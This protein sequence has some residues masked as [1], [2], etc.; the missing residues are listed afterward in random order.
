MSNQSFQI[1]NP[2][3][4]WGR[5]QSPD[6]QH[7]MLFPLNFLTPFTS[8]PLPGDAEYAVPFPP[9]LEQ[10]YDQGNTPCCGGVTGCQNQTAMNS[11]PGE[12][13]KYHWHDLYDLSR[14]IENIPPQIEGT[15]VRGIGQA[16]K[17]GLREVVN[18]VMQ[19]RDPANGINDFYWTT[20][21]D[22]VRSAIAVGKQPVCFGINWYQAMNNIEMVNGEAWIVKSI[23][24]TDDWGDV[25]GGHMILGY[26]VFDSKQA[27]RLLGSWIAQGFPPVLI[28]YP[29]LQRLLDDAGECMVVFDRKNEPAPPPV[30]SAKRV[31]IYSGLNARNG[32][33]DTTAS[34]LFT[35]K[36]TALLAIEDVQTD[37]K[38][39]GNWLRVSSNAVLSVW[40]ADWTGKTVVGN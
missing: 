6:D 9:G 23:G 22:G 2:N 37:A 12:V 27:V 32:P 25:L 36:S 39:R 11:F 16:M 33:N 8:P 14:M 7:L 20:K 34:V 17:R 4:K 15:S 18:N 5:I 38:G 35:F 40:V 19:E 29:A 3:T 31:R 10:F 28:P 21:V 13:H 24:A 1:V 30:T 26:E